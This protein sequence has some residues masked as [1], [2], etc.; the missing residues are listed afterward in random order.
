[1]IFKICCSE[2]I[3]KYHVGY[4]LLFVLQ[5]YLLFDFIISEYVFQNGL[6][7]DYTKYTVGSR[8]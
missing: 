6:F 4:Y 7:R 5:N 8:D 2:I 1:M 3:P